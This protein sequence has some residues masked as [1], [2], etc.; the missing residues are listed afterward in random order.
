[1]NNSLINVAFANN[2]LEILL[3]KKLITYDQYSRTLGLVK[4]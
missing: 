3:N 4:I 1:M 2:V